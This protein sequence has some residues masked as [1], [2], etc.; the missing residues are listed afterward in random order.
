MIFQTGFK[1]GLKVHCNL[2][3][4]GGLVINCCGHLQHRILVSNEVGD[5]V[6]DVR[7]A[8]AGGQLVQLE[9][10]LPGLVLEKVPSEGS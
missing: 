1:G 5:D 6:Q 3:R 4:M 2:S 10:L 9:L 7:L 8:Q